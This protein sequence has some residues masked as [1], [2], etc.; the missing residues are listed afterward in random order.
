MAKRIKEEKVY[1]SEEQGIEPEETREEEQTEM[2]TG[3]REEEIY[4]EEGREKLEEGDEIEPWEEGF[5]EGAEGK[6]ELGHC[7]SCGRVLD[8]EA[9]TIVEKEIGG[10]NV[11]FCSDACAEKGPRKREEKPV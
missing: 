1:A 4:E 10:K 6:G 8:Q 3:E 2:E 9:D 7:A 11:W 5:M